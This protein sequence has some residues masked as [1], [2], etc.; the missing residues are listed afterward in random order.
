MRLG[1]P[2][3]LRTSSR[4]RPRSLARR[5]SWPPACRPSP[6]Q[7]C[8]PFSGRRSPTKTRV[9]ELRPLSLPRGAGVRPYVVECSPPRG[10]ITQENIRSTHVSPRLPPR[11]ESTHQRSEGEHRDKCAGNRG[12]PLRSR[13]QP[14]AV[15]GRALPSPTRLRPCGGLQVSV[16]T[17]SSASLAGALRREEETCALAQRRGALHR[18]SESHEQAA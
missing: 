7:A 17:A 6:T 5:S 18:R 3:P 15:N 8:F 4:R 12:Y 11:H 9:G 10:E 14:L 16:L 13:V 1:E 2:R